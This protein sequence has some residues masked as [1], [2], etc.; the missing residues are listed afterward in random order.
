MKKYRL[1]A[2]AIIAI[3][4]IV[5]GTSD[6][7]KSIYKSTNLISLGINSENK[8]EVETTEVQ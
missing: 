5:I 4:I 1:L 7:I 8:E 2:T 6:P 3:G